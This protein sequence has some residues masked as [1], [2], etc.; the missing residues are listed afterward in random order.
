[1]INKH[2]YIH[3]YNKSTTYH[4][5][6]MVLPARVHELEEVATVAA[7]IVQELA[8]VGRDVVLT[9]HLQLIIQLRRHLV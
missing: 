8:D 9:H 4:L 1:M 6:T 7:R 3:T 2:T 5:P